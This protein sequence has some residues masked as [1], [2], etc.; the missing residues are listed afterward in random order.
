MDWAVYS[1]F[2]LAAWVV[3]LIPGPTTMLVVSYSLSLGWRGA[4]PVVLGVA[5][6]DA[7]AVSLSLAG[8]GAVLLASATLFEVL[9]LAGAAYL[10]VLGIRM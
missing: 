7:T 4:L 1:A 6:G 9:K 3:V 10:V 2:F 5:L 8:L